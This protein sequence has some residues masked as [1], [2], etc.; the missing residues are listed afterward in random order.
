MSEAT[1]FYV[2]WTGSSAF[3][4]NGIRVRDQEPIVFLPT[5]ISGC[6][7]W[8]D[9]NDNDAVVYNSF[10]QV[11]SWSNKG[12]I[13]GQFDISGTAAVQYGVATQNGLNTVSFAVSS[14]MA[15]QFQFNFQPRSLFIVTRE[16]SV[17]QGQ[18]SPWLT[19]ETAGGMETFSQHDGTTVYY[20]GKHG[21]VFPEL[22]AESPTDYNGY[23]ALFSFVNSTEA[24]DNFVGVNGSQISLTYSNIATGYNTS[25]ITYFLGDY[26]N[27]TPVGVSQDMCEMILYNT[28]LSPPDREN[29]E[30]YL[31]TKW[32]ITEPPFSPQNIPGLQLWMDATQT[33]TLTLSSGSNVDSWSNAGAAGGVLNAQCNV[34]YVNTDFGFQTVEFPPQTVIAGNMAFPY[35]TRTAFCVFQNLQAM[36]ELA[37]PYGNLF[38]CGTAGGRQIGY[39]YDSNT[40][41]YYL[42]LCQQS[43][44]CPASGPLPIPLTNDR[45]L[46]I[47]GVDSNTYTSS[48]M[49]YDG[50]SNINIDTNGANLFNLGTIEY[51]IGSPVSGSPYFRVGEII[52]YDSLLTT[53]QISS[54]AGYLVNKW[55]ISSFSAIV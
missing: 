53:A 26:L 4:A 21:V 5:D 23:A 2:S 43:Y 35:M 3:G 38:N 18:P 14:F 24:I 29:V 9:G 10:L 32:G 36:D 39:N 50:G 44:N 19:C 52:E 49:Y 31:I 12:E 22:A 25:N 55:A 33:S 27:G 48:I 54:V 41:T 51:T 6:A 37:Y 20:I 30:K 8:L 13:G 42:A 28:A 45:H 46:A 1:D 7:L 40:D 34:A 17:A 11:Q 47:W 15:G 16:T